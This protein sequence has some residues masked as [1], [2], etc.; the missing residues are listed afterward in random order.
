M[1]D[2]LIKAKSGD[3]TAAD[4]II[5]HYRG[6]IYYLMNEY[7]IDNKADCYDVVIERILKSFYEF[8]IKTHT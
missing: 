5:A 7:E 8:E 6:L 1:I 4:K 2:E 3:I